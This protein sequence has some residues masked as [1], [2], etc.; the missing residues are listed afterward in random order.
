MKR[1]IKLSKCLK[2]FIVIIAMIFCIDILKNSIFKDIGVDSVNFIRNIESRIGLIDDKSTFYNN[3]NNDLI[4]V[5][6][7]NS[8][9]SDYKPD[10]LVKPNIV[11]LDS[12]V[13]EEKYMQQE[14]ATALEELFQNAK[15]NN[16]T[17]I[18]SSAYRSYQTQ[19]NIYN[20]YYRQK[21]SS[22]T[23]KYVATP[24]ESE[25]QTGL[26]IDVTNPSRC[27]DKTSVEAQWIDN[28][29][30]K[31][32]FILRYPENKED[33][34]GYNYEPWHIRYVGKDVAK[35]IYIN[36]TTLEEYLAYY[37]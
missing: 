25:H 14:A 26:A 24:G 28:N 11:F 3:K 22:Y 12:S 27:F 13:E 23:K 8:L 17:L 37:N 34:T 21:G 7:E 4:L 32:G 1:K 30:Y 29:A 10:N 31:Y 15:Q 19:V 2:I 5:N 35:K 33:V 20:K 9:S 16:I 18:G 36:S 6:K